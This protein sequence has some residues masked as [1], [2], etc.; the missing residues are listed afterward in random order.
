MTVYN[1]DDH[2]FISL[3]VSLYIGFELEVVKRKEIRRELLTA[4]ALDPFKS[5]KPVNNIEKRKTSRKHIKRIIIQSRNKRNR[6]DASF[7]EEH[8]GPE[9]LTAVG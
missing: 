7:Y 5:I 1:R 4:T 8:G 3:Q 6:I 9:S 2:V